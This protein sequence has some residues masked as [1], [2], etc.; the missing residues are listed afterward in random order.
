MALGN[1]PAN[2]ETF[3]ITAT[4]AFNGNYAE[5]YMTILYANPALG[6]RK[7]LIVAEGFDSGHIINPESKTGES[8]IVDFKKYVNESQS[9]NLKELLLNNPLYDI[10]YVDW[11]RG[12]DNIKKNA[13]LLKDIIRRVNTLKAN[14]GSTAKNV[15]IGQSMGG[16]IT[17]W[18][19]KEMENAGE[20]H[21]TNLF[22]SYDSPH[23]GANTPLAYQ[24]LARHERNLYIKTGVVTVGAVES[25]QLNRGGPS[26][27]QSLSI[28]NTSASRQMLINY[29]DDFGNVD[30]SFHNQWQTELKNMG[31]PQGSSGTSLRKVAVSNGSECATS[32]LVAPGGSLLSYV[33]K[34]NTRFIS[35]LAG[36]LVL[37]I[38]AANLN[39][40][41]L[42]LGILPG[43]ND[44]K[45]EIQLNA[46]GDTGGNR[47]FYNKVT[48]TKRLLWIL[49]I[50]V[51]I[52]NKSNYAPT[53]LA[54]DS[55]P[56]GFLKPPVDLQS[57][58]N[59][60][61]F[62][63]YNIVASNQPTF[64]FVPA[65]SALD[66]GSGNVALTAADYNTKYIGAS[67]P[68][69]TKSSPFANFITASNGGSSANESHLSIRVRNG[70][71]MAT[72]LYNNTVTGYT[73]QPIAPNCTYIC[74]DVVIT[75][76]PEFC[77]N[78]YYS[79]SNLPSSANIS[80]SASGSI[81]IIG[82][83][84]ANPVS[85][86][87]VSNGVG[88]LNAY[89]YSSSW[90]GK[91][92]TKNLTTRAVGGTTC[93]GDPDLD[94]DC[95]VPFYINA[96]NSTYAYYPNPANNELIVSSI[97]QTIVSNSQIN[98]SES[99]IPLNFE[100]EL[101]DDEG[102]KVK[103]MKSSMNNKDIVIDTHNLPNGNYFLHKIEGKE[104]IK[105]QIIIIH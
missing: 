4:Q 43:R 23:Q 97:N 85:V 73:A 48:F 46:N 38:L 50:T 20:Q 101:Y 93:T 52:T 99:P 63:K 77:A 69:G 41:A 26:P 81:S 61:A 90:G 80:W 17:R 87:K 45:F 96:R 25:F 57:T 1:N 104:V 21:Q 100:I 9:N 39:Q 32:Q 24:Y 86:T 18:A 42:F 31:Y 3:E 11:K 78:S 27:Y 74:N 34:A 82:S 12:T 19:L 37:P 49:P 22:I 66:I 102:K 7:P 64:N 72:E 62:I 98:I 5:G 59:V 40:S 68:T 10:V 88:T 83:A 103:A 58:S 55:F 13:Y 14:A 76:P 6:L 51:T 70:D 33:G 29:V 75:G 94:T 15:I 65:T 92:V 16:L 54:Y 56:G 35:D 79:I 30:N 53:T 71:W 47:V 105:K 60:N 91:T 44:F 67:P 89:I 28:A 2:P 84:N 8:S 36:M 95:C